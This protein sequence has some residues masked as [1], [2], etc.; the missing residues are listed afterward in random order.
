VDCLDENAEPRT[1]QA[2]GWYARILQHEI[3]DLNGVLYVD[4]MKSRTF[5]SVEN[6]SRAWKDLSIDETK[7][8]LG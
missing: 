2:T 6:Y 4:R 8:K 3:D 1:I 7:V 5:M